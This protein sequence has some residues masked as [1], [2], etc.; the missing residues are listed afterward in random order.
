[1]QISDIVVDS[2]VIVHK[3]WTGG[4]A[5]K[6]QGVAA[7]GHLRQLA[8]IV[9][10]AVSSGTVGPLGP[11][12]VGVVDEV[13]GCV[14][15]G[16]F[17][18]FP[19]MLPGVGPGTI[20]ERIADVVVSDGLAVE[21]SQQIIGRRIVFFWVMWFSVKNLGNN[22]SYYSRL[23][24]TRC[25]HSIFETKSLPP[26][27]C[28]APELPQHRYSKKSLSG[29]ATDAKRGHIRHILPK[30]LFPMEILFCLILYIRNR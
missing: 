7:D 17:F 14:A 21:G 3:Q 10:I 24:I 15:A 16:H 30:R 12:A 1:M 23:E 28:L 25:I 11:H 26:G 19:A 8:V 18:Q 4:I 22:D 29:P 20:G 13:P 5:T 27:L 2:S 6:T 9:D